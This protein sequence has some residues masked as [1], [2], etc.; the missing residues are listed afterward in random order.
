MNGNDSFPQERLTPAFRPRQQK[1]RPPCQDNCPNCG[2]IRA[3]I[4]IV[5]QRAKTGL[6][7]EEAYARAWRT[8]TEVNP[9]PAVLGRIC[10][11]PCE[12][13]CNRSVYDEA[14][15][16][17]AMERFLGD[18]AIGS[19]LSLQR[20]DGWHANPSIG[21]V[22][23]GP[24]GLSFAYQMAR[25]GYRVTVYEEHPEPGGMLRYGVP[26]YRLPPAILDAEIQ[27]ILDLGVAL[28]LDTRIGRDVTLA[29]LRASHAALYLGLGAQAGR[30]LDIPGEEG[31]SVWT[32]IDYLERVNRGQRVELGRHVT[33][34][35]GGNTAVDAARTAR[36]GGR[37]VTIVY[38][39]GRDDMPA[40]AA[41]IEEALA[42]GVT[43][44]THAIPTGLLRTAEG[45]LEAVTCVRMQPGDPD[46]SGRRKPV[47]IANSEFSLATDSLI[48]AVSQ[49]PL[50]DGLSGLRRSGSW[51]GTDDA[52]YV[53]ESVLAGGDVLGLGIA[54]NAI[55][56]GRRAAERLHTR[57]SGATDSALP[58]PRSAPIGP[59]HVQLDLK[60]RQPRAHPLQLPLTERLSP[61]SP[62]VSGTLSEA[63]FLAE[64]DRCHSCGDC[65][66]C[67]HCA[68]Y[69]TKASFVRLAE[70]GP[71]MYFSLALDACEECGKC[72]AVCPCGYLE[73]APPLDR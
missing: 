26:D 30:M 20:F 7:R 29:E 10:P 28:R 71:G 16:I 61:A 67:E 33:V 46:E 32:G 63:A 35:G 56:Q 12:S 62:E 9:F 64:V 21:V 59:E 51:L 2:D 1:K 41:E 73:S 27:R 69:C 14:L 54:G 8:I 19:R 66:G 53:D 24:S 49:F 36:R 42:E 4:G 22:G 68:M 13:R 72:I 57:L 65:V 39:R 23:S 55:V 25:R 47:A 31:P 3:W 58:E 52:G 40:I 60:P 34:V 44:H 37:E 48:A 17:N 6:G 70:V 45:I 18:W 5:A 50:L 15:A 38:R 43:L 11:H